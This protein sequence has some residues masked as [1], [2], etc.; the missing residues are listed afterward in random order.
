MV[1]STHITNTMKAMEARDAV[2]WGPVDDRRNLTAAA[3]SAPSYAGHW[4]GPRPV[5]YE[6]NSRFRRFTCGTGQ[7]T[8][9]SDYYI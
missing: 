6:I 3:P 1:G 8:G 2:T 4:K 7:P 5:S 9:L